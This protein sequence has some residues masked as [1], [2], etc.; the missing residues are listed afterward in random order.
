MSLG[1]FLFFKLLL[2]IF[3]M[4]NYNQILFDNNLTLCFNFNLTTSSGIVNLISVISY[5]MWS[6]FYAASLETSY[7]YGE[8]FEV[9]LCNMLF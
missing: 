1:Y 7:R 6:F 2:S 3:F 8:S 5:I 4:C 9:L